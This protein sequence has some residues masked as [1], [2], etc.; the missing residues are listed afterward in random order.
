MRIEILQSRKA[1]APYR[2]RWNELALADPRDGFFRTYEWYQAWMEHIRPDAEPYV[3]LVRDAAG[4]IIAVAP[5]CRLSFNDLG[6]RVQTIAW[7][8][9][10]VV[11][12]DFLDLAA[13]PEDRAAAAA[14]VLEALGERSGDWKMLMLG[15]LLSEGA[16]DAA[17][18]GFAASRGLPLRRQEERICPY[19]ALPASFDEYLAT[20]G[21]S[22]RY[23]I[24]RRIRDV[25]EKRG[26]VVTVYSDVAG[27]EANL[28]ILFD[29]HLARWRKAGQPGTF[30]RPGFAEF[31]HAVSAAPPAGTSA[32][33]YVLT[34][35]GAP[36]A[37]LLTFYF[38]ESALYY[39]AGWDPD[40]ALA[41]L[42]PGV[43]LMASSIRDAIDGGLKYYEF[44]RGDEDYKSRW[45]KTYRTTGTVFCANA[46]MARL[47][48]QACS[49]KD[50]VKEHLPAPGR[51]A[52]ASAAEPC[53]EP[54]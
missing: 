44:L 36:A 35:E 5:L 51:R 7:A 22:T 23:H 9:R 26:G 38:G 42:S 2:E 10:E 49:Y 46:L 41:A 47:Y 53:R 43:V 8:G 20:L 40:S 12:G 27:L 50:R 39:Q 28:H 37:A 1:L 17:L 45:T 11:S 19:I 18:A 13:A 31:L 21:N 25:V 32:R 30:G 4:Q 33:L 48:L 6:F 34:H 24:R 3:V 14:A 29:L 16:T 15:E 54:V 52:A